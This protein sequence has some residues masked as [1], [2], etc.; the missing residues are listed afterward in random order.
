MAWVKRGRS[1]SK[2]VFGLSEGISGKS[3]GGRQA[4]F[5]SVLVEDKLRIL[6]SFKTRFRG[7]AGR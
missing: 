5:D 3:A 7:P 4:K 6:V 2:A 1:I